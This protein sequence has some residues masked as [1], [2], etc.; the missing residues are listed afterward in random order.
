MKKYFKVT[1]IAEGES[2][3]THLSA[4]TSY[5]KGGEGYNGRST[6]RGYY[7]HV[8]PV[9][10]EI[11]DTYTSE[12]TVCFTGFKVFLGEIK[13]DS[14]KAATEANRIFE[15]VRFEGL[16]SM[17]RGHFNGAYSFNFE[18]EETEY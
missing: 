9:K 18:E 3:I 8:T 7:A 4:Y 16:Q 1:S 11:H 12:T 13:R 14:K 5:N 10:L 15:G 17:I 6:K 2:K